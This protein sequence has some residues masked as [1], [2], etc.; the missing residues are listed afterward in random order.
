MEIIVF[1]VQDGDMSHLKLFF[2]SLMFLIDSDKNYT[3]LL[4]NSIVVKHLS[5][6]VGL[7]SKP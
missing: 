2:P 4:A 1:S 6:S 3:S 7:W 5:L